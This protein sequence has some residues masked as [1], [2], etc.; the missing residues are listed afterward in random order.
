MDLAENI[1]ESLRAIQGN[2][3]RTVLTALIVAIGIMSL[4]GILT[5]VDSIKYSI[6]ETFSSLG[7]NSF[8]IRAKGYQMRRNRGGK[9]EKVYPPVSYFQA[10]QYQRFYGD[11]ARISISTTITGAATVK[12]N[13]VKTN[14]NILVAGGDEHFLTNEN[15]NLATG[16]P[17]STFEL[18]NGTDVAIIGSEIKSK[19]FRNLNPVGKTIT[20]LGRHFKIVGDMEVSGSSMGGRGSDRMVLI[21]LETANQIPRTQDLTY[22]LKT[23]VPN[24]EDLQY[25]MG[26]ATG[27]MRNVRQD[28]PGQEDSFEITR[29]DSMLKTLDD[30]SGFVKVGGFLVGFITLLGAA[31]GLMNILMVSVSERTREIGIRKALGATA[32]K[33]RQQFLIEA[34]V[35]CLLGGVAGIILGVGIGN[36]IAG[37]ISEGSF[38]V[39]WLWVFVGLVV[40]VTVG[41]ISGWY[42][43]FKASKLDPI[44]ALRYE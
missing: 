23:A 8:D 10:K 40:C 9:S 4:V 26:E 29:S 44:E 25:M 17:F 27:I 32:Q 36:L 20:L 12:Y 43:A 15:Y 3:L 5:A 7:A 11:K 24:A 31:I 37:A 14:P 22:S 39:P 1:K 19:L 21:P 16:R 2:L 28:K 30:V 34:I 13:Q 42:P 6:G 41:V 35:I 33:I 18:E 38:M